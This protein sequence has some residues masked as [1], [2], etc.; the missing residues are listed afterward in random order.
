MTLVEDARTLVIQ[1]SEHGARVRT[2]R[3]HDAKAGETFV[4]TGL[5]DTEGY[6]VGLRYASL[7]PFEPEEPVATGEGADAAE[8][9]PPLSVAD[10]QPVSRTNAMPT[11]P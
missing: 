2:L 10:T 1:E 6:F 4:L 5:P 7:A 3:P 8:P 11:S 9:T